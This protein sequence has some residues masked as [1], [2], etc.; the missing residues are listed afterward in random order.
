[1]NGAY[2]DQMKEWSVKRLIDEGYIVLSP[3]RK[4]YVRV[5][6]LLIFIIGVSLFG[7]KVPYF[8]TIIVLIL[9]TLEFVL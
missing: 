8:I 3:K 9:Y 6:I 4:W 5:P 2:D 1:M 7:T